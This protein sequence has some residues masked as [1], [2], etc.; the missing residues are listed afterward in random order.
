MFCEEMRKILEKRGVEF[1]FD[2][3]VTKINTSDRR[4]TS[5]ETEKSEMPVK[6][7][8]LAN[9]IDTTRLAKDLNTAVPIVPVKGYALT[10]EKTEPDS[11]HLLDK[12][13]RHNSTFYYIVEFENSYRIVGFGDFDG[14]EKKIRPERVERLEKFLRENFPRLKLKGIDE[15]NFLWYKFSKLLL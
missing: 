11:K 8:V 10:Y 5:I 1:I 12:T 3:S 4:V 7:L 13:F 6:N 2:T 9:G 14:P 15:K